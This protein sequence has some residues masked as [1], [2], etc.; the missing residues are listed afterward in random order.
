MC[1]LFIS[2][3]VLCRS[4]RCVGA[5]RVDDS[6]VSNCGELRAAQRHFPLARR[7]L[8][9]QVNKTKTSG[10]ATTLVRLE[11]GDLNSRKLCE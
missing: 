11:R 3:K 8:V 6:V 7:A 2:G 10:D 1:A 9:G 4:Q 5:Q